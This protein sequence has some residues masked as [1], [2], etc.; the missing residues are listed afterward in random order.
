MLFFIKKDVDKMAWETL[1][2]VF[3]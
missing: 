3:I 1:Q 2:C